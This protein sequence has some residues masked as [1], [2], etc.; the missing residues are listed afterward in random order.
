MQIVRHKPN[1]IVV[2]LTRVAETLSGL[3]AL[4]RGLSGHDR[5]RAARFRF[6][7]D[8]ARLA[9][10]RRLLA[11]LLRDELGWTP[12]PLEVALTEKGR[13]YLRERPDVA[14]SISHAGDVVAV[15]LTVGAQVGVDVESLDRRVELDSLAERI[16]SAA[17]LVRF[18]AVPNAEKARAFFRAWT[19]KE[20]VL[21]ARGV[22]LFG[23]MEGI[24]AP[25]DGTAETIHTGLDE[26]WHVQPLMV[27]EGYVG[28]V[29]CD[30]PRCAIRARDFTLAEL[31]AA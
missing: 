24:S 4:E 27:P 20:A 14:F 8:R 9:L 1:S 28:T 18:R 31:T 12:Q 15:A 10:G 11:V 2:G 30:D 7:E 6:P 3:D 22:G 29:A 13:P 19:G 16:F 23:G 17:D 25:L 21:K 5:D 26:A